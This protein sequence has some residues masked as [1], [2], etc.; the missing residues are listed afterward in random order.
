MGWDKKKLVLREDLCCRQ[1]RKWWGWINYGQNTIPSIDLEFSTTIY[2]GL[3]F[4]FPPSKE[5]ILLVYLCI[6]KFFSMPQDNTQ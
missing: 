2:S 4:Y 5:T 1:E 3:K 6:R